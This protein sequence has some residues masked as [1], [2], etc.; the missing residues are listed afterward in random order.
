MK[1]LS[2]TANNIEYKDGIWVSK[3]NEPISYPTNGNDLCNDIEEVSFWFLH[4]RNCII[5]VI[6]RFYDNGLFLGVGE[7]NGFIT[8]EL[9]NIG[10]DAVLVEPGNGVFNGKSKGI[11]N[12]IKSTINNAGFIEQSVDNIGIFDVVEHIEAV[13]YL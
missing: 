6:K 12:I 7:G 3:T 8:K 9:L 2:I 4:R 13:V 10:I 5:E 11:K 1:N